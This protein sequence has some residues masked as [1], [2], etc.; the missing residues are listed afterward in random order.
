MTNSGTSLTRRA[1]LLGGAAALV[2]FAPGSGLAQDAPTLTPEAALSRVRSGDLL[3]VD[4][5]QPGEWASTGLPEGGH[6]LDMR[7]PDFIEALLALSGGDRDRP[8]AL[9]C[10]AGG[11]SNYMTAQLDAAGF[12]RII[13]VPEGMLGSRAGPGW[14]GRNLPVTPP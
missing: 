4:I 9:I 5:R 11:R 1:A 10:A 14:I 3:L 12:T 13:D 2:A 8:I 6:P 7:R